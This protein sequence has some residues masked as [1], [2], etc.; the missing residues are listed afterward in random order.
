[1]P[2]LTSLEERIRLL[3]ELG[4]EFIIP[5]FFT[6]QLAQVSAR[7]FTLQLQKYL[8]MKSLVIGPDFALGKG[9]EGN[10]SVLQSLG[11]EMGFTVE[12]VPFMRVEGEVVSSTA[13]RDSLAQ[14]DI[15]KARRFL[16]RTFSLSG[17]VVH[18][19]R[20]GR[21]LGFP[22]ANLGV[23]SNQ[24]LPADGVY[25]TRVYIGEE[26]YPS[27][28]NI[29]RRPTF[30]EQGRAVEVYLFNFDAELY[31]QKLRIELLEY[32][33]EERQF[34]SAEELAIQ[35]RRDVEQAKEIL[36]DKKW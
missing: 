30:E 28:T 6:P 19:A 27:V 33:R 25:A 9:R 4:V 22:T 36:E 23:N 32:L 24:A 21:F 15:S 12:V 18:G 29:G 34:S 20:R 13:I 5:L 11:K 2:Y 31:E 7:E 10:A 3:Q 26:L 14:G 1:L 17:Q 35:I 8:R 16:G